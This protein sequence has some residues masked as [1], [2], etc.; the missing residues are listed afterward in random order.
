MVTGYTLA[1]DFP[2]TPDAFQSK[3]GSNGDAFVSVVNPFAYSKF[4]VYSTYLGGSQG[5]VGYGIAGD[6]AGSIYVTGYTLSPDFPTTP[7]GFEP[8]WGGGID[9]FLTKL[10]PGVAGPAGLLSSTYLGQ[11]GVYSPTALTLGRD[12]TI[13]IVGWGGLG[14]PSTANALQGFGGGLRDGFIMVLTK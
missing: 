9:M 10:K 5:E 12:G 14:L 1:T 6:S 7:D 4:L 11:R 2:V 13:Y 3:A 8:K